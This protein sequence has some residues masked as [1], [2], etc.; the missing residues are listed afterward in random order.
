MISF[1]N[2]QKSLV[3]L[4]LEVKQPNCKGAVGGHPGGGCQ[5]MMKGKTKHPKNN[6]WKRGGVGWNQ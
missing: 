4:C 6:V 5:S 1:Y 3:A 2:V